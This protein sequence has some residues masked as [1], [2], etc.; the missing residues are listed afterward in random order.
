[1][2][3]SS[4]HTNS[5]VR[6]IVL[7]TDGKYLNTCC[8]G[9][10]QPCFNPCAGIKGRRIPGAITAGS[11]PY[12]FWGPFTVTQATSGATATVLAMSAAGP[13]IV[14]ETVTGIPTTTDVW[15]AGS[16]EFTPTAVPGSVE[17]TCADM[18]ADWSIYQ[19]YFA[20]GWWAKACQTYGGIGPLCD[21]YLIYLS[22]DGGKYVPRAG[23]AIGSVPDA[24]SIILQVDQDNTTFDRDNPE[25][26]VFAWGVGWEIDAA[27]FYPAGLPVGYGLSARLYWV[28]STT[29]ALPG[30][31]AHSWV[32][33][34]AGGPKYSCFPW[35]VYT[36]PDT[37]VAFASAAEW[38]EY[39]GAFDGWTEKPYPCGAYSGGEALCDDPEDQVYWST[40]WCWYIGVPFGNTG[41]AT[42]EPFP[43]WC[44]ERWASLVFTGE[45][46]ACL[47]TL[48][49]IVTCEDYFLPARIEFTISG[50]TG[51]ISAIQAPAWLMC[52][53]PFTVDETATFRGLN[54]PCSVAM[55]GACCY[56]ANRILLWPDSGVSG[57]ISQ[58]ALY[59][60]APWWI[61]DCD[62]DQGLKELRFNLGSFCLNL[63]TVDGVKHW[64][65]AV[66]IEG[67]LWGYSAGVWQALAFF[68]V[69]QYNFD[70][71]PA[72]QNA[73]HVYPGMQ[74]SSATIIT[75]AFTDITSGGVLTITQ[76]WPETQTPGDP[77]EE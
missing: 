27:T 50:M 67:Q 48:T 72:D 22:W 10:P 1:M 30:V 18:T 13:M 21:S 52:G 9:T 41:L 37:G 2:I 47:S 62:A 19:Y 55:D 42:G 65:F 53:T 17:Q 69:V 38:E 66:T 46:E 36:N 8:C 3:P 24:E 75:N 76:V 51:T 64:Q 5:P 45:S 57:P 49:P 28:E 61:D 40:T 73:M 60:A 31:P 68:D 58:E 7:A 12:T 6:Q 23:T 63:V 77:G 39:C 74:S 56:G 43:T 29:P 32:M 14:A 70:V 44:L 25:A 16:F 20:L 34:V 11:P 59:D 15:A 33:A 35:Y 71:I 4:V 26:G 54:V